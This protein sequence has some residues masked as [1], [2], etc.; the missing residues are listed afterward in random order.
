MQSTGN[1]IP[2]AAAPLLAYDDLPPGSDLGREFTSGGVVITA[3][4]AAPSVRAMRWARRRAAGRAARDTA[5]LLALMGLWLWLMAPPQPIASLTPVVYPLVGL[6]AGSIFLL[7]WQG[8][9]AQCIDALRIARRQATLIVADVQRLRIE[10][11]GPFGALSRSDETS[12]VRGVEVAR[13]EGKA[14]FAMD[15]WVVRVTLE[16]GTALD[17]LQGRDESELSCIVSL[18]R[19]A[20]GIVRE[21]PTGDAYPTR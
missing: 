14:W 21:I 17:L 7:A 18:M 2:T 12:K 1:P 9:S 20:L 13:F 4:C 8:R 3:A 16:D 11:D 19:R 15:R 10:T 5:G 6:L